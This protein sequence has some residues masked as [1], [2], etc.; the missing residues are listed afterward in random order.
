MTNLPCRRGSTRRR[1]YAAGVSTCQLPPQDIIGAGGEADVISGAGSLQLLRRQ[2][3]YIIFGVG[4]LQLLRRRRMSRKLRNELLD[5]R[6]V[7]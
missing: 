5:V 6:V 2:R 3:S 1:L 4:A 7:I